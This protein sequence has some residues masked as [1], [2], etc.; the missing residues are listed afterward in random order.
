MKPQSAKAKGTRFEHFIAKEITEAGLGRAGRE[1]NS[2][3]GFRKGDI[4]S[5]L[6]FLIE[7]KNE[8][9][10]NI[11]KN[12]DQAVKQARIG[13][14]SSN[15]WALV[16]RDPRYP[17]FDRVYITIDFWEFLGLMKRN[18][19]PRVKKPD[20]ELKWKLENLKSAIQKV[21]KEL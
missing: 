20:R 14:Y 4:A 9:Q 8:K 3:A 18:S 17:E 1:A 11:L 16:S 15:K 7:A 12:I 5:N 10:V 2:G 21:I 6:L 19:E 13:N